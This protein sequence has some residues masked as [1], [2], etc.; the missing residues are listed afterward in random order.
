MAIRFGI[1]SPRLGANGEELF[2][3]AAELGLDVEWVAQVDYEKDP[4]FDPAS[5]RRHLEWARLHGVRFC[6]GAMAFMNKTGL[7]SKIAADRDFARKGLAAWIPIFHELGAPH[8]LV[9]NFGK[10]K[11]EDAEN[12]R[13]L[14]EALREAAPLAEANQ[15]TLDLETTLDAG[16]LKSVLQRTG[17]PRVK[18]YF[19]TANVFQ[20]GLEPVGQILQLGSLIGQIHFKESNPATLTSDRPLGE[21]QVDFEGV[22]GAMKSIDYRGEVVFET[23]PGAA[24]MASARRNLEFSWKLIED[25]Y[26]PGAVENEKKF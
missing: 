12:E 6:S 10:A 5:R 21:G 15:A 7:G 26:G 22:V 3:R 1:M 14:V 11:I 24:P 13:L 8:V 2:R 9:A 18:V 16:R 23:P 25:F 20:Y 19:D 4:L 17:S